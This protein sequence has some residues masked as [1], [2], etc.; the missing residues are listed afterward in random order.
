MPGPE[1]AIVND[2]TSFEAEFVCNLVCGLLTLEKLDLKDLEEELF[3]ELGNP[4]TT[5]ALSEMDLSI[6]ASFELLSCAADLEDLSFP[7][8]LWCNCASD[9]STPT[10]SAPWDDDAAAPVESCF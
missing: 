10:Q 5:M 6:C 4:A 3:F 2:L 9:T 7:D 1:I 8:A